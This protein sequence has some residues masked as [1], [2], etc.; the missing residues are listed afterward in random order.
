MVLDSSDQG[1]RKIQWYYV[2]RDAYDIAVAVVYSYKYH[3]E[4][5]G[6]RSGCY[7][8]EQQKYANDDSGKSDF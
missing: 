8:Y 6:E 3:W 5:D 4:D 7:C 1:T 2:L